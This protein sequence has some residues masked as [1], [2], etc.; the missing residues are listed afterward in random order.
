MVRPENFVNHL[1]ADFLLTL[2]KLRSRTCVKTSSP[3]VENE[4]LL[5][6]SRPVMLLSAYKKGSVSD[7]AAVKA[8]SPYMAVPA[9]DAKRLINHARV[10]LIATRVSE[11]KCNR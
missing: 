5:V 3:C 7:V 4:T 1:T 9:V 6:P 10:D 11:R 2:L 8:P